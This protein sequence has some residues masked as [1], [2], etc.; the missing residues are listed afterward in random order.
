MV[1]RV[2]NGDVIEVDINETLPEI[3]HLGFRVDFDRHILKNRYEVQPKEID[4]RKLLLHYPQTL[5]RKLLV[6]LTPF[7]SQIFRY[8]FDQFLVFFLR[9]P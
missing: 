5:N 9:K 4:K 3:C 8:L 7:F 2:I 1:I 6:S